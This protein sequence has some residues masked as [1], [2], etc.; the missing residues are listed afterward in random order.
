MMA[1]PPSLDSLDNPDSLQHNPTPRPFVWTGGPRLPIA[2]PSRRSS[3]RDDLDTTPRTVVPLADR[4]FD[5][6]MKGF[7]ADGIAAQ[8]GHPD[9]SSRRQ[10][11]SPDTEQEWQR[12]LEL[13]Q[14]RLPH[15]HFPSAPT[16]ASDSRRSFFGPRE[17]LRRPKASPL[18]PHTPNTPRTPSTFCTPPSTPYT[19]DSPELE[20]PDDNVPGVHVQ[21][22]KFG[23]SDS[24]DGS[25]DA[26]ENIITPFPWWEFPDPRSSVGEDNK[27]SGEMDPTDYISNDSYLSY[28]SI[29]PPVAQH[30]PEVT[31]LRPWQI[32]NAPSQDTEPSSDRAS[33]S[34]RTLRP[35]LSI[36]TQISRSQNEALTRGQTTHFRQKKT[37]PFFNNTTNRCSNYPTADPAIS[38][39]H[40]QPS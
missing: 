13:H 38:E 8:S 31:P 21:N 11:L 12:V 24:E 40:T 2:G 17:Q 25:F 19:P 30:Y 23:D 32:V 9:R 27:S 3:T 35:R 1:D 39:R 5:I 20:T 28:K 22:Q 4:L 10:A 33:S 7:L 36:I 16:S 14:P 29:L 37:V 34:T 6:A 15:I 18:T 26:L